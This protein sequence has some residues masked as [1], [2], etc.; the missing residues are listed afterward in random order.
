MALLDGDD[1][2]AFGQFYCTGLGIKVIIMVDII[3]PENLVHC[4]LYRSQA[5]FPL[6]LQ[7]EE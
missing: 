4:I 2:R 3:L 6:A 7:E 5:V 1:E